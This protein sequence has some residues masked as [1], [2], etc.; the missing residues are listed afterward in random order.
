MWYTIFYINTYEEM[1]FLSNNA[2]KEDVN[3]N[4]LYGEAIKLSKDDFI[5]KY[6]VKPKRFIN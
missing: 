3:I 1:I 2:T 4:K 5:K 6:N